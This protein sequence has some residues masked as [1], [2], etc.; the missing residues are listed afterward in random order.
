[1]AGT[2]LACFHGW[3]F[4]VP[5]F[6]RPLSAGV[7]TVA[8]LPLNA[9]PRALIGHLDRERSGPLMAAMDACNA[10]WGRGSVVPA[11]AGV[12]AARKDW[13]TKFEM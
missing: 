5:L 13:S 2:G 1:M 3:D 7:V 6:P 10:Q 9:T 4:D 12:A 11:R 8:L